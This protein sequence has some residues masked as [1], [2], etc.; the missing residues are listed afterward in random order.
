MILVS[1]PRNAWMKA[2]VKLCQRVCPQPFLTS[3]REKH[4]RAFVGCFLFFLPLSLIV[5]RAPAQEWDRPGRGFLQSNEN[6]P[7]SFLIQIL[8]ILH[9][10][11]LTWPWS[12]V[13][14]DRWWQPHHHQPHHKGRESPAAW[15]RQP[16]FSLC[17]KGSCSFSAP[18]ENFN[19]LYG[20]LRLFTYFGKLSCEWFFISNSEDYTDII[21]FEMGSCIYQE[22]GTTVQKLCK[23][24]YMRCSI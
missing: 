8:L 18:N 14:L 20:S 1:Q 4:P 16:C 6:L 3:K 13:A 24:P 7:Q 2:P 21:N 22:P 9:Q 15:H 10:P 12:P 17:V 5:P 23:G 19:H 11:P